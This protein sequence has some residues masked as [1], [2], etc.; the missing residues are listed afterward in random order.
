MPLFYNIT[1][2]VLDGKV[3]KV[4]G[5]GLSSNDYTTADKDKLEAAPIIVLSD[6]EPSVKTK[7][8]IWIN[9][10]K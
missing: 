6:T 5:M 4:P 2:A 1:P 9:T 8:M 10:S 3:D 7:D